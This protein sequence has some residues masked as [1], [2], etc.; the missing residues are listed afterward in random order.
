MRQT[1]ATST[2]RFCFV[3]EMLLLPACGAMLHPSTFIVYHELSVSGYYGLCAPFILLQRALCSPCRTHSVMSAN[4]L[5]GAWIG[6]AQLFP[7]SFVAAC[8]FFSFLFSTPLVQPLPCLVSVN[9][10]LQNFLSTDHHGGNK[11]SGK[12]TSCR[13]RSCRYQQCPPDRSAAES[14]QK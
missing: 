10:F 5:D 1:P 6:L 14:S 4:V 11:G 13:A 3:P 12:S 9:P 7:V 8:R 2:L